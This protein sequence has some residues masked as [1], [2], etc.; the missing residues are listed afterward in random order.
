[1]KGSVAAL[2]AVVAVLVGVCA[3]AGVEGSHGKLRI[4]TLEKPA[5]CTEADKAR[6]GDRLRMH[7]HGELLDGTVFDDSHNHGAPFEF[8][9]GKGMVIRGWEEGVLGMCVGEKRRLL[10]PPSMG[11]GSHAV[12][13]IPANS[14]LVFDVELISIVNRPDAG[15]KREEL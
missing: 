3:A 9:L 11:Y 8:V 10:V 2:F 12:G 1:M 14:D 7:Y 4:S 15:T 6:N 5:A 13:P